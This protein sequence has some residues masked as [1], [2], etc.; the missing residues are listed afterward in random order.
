M[1]NVGDDV[2]QG[3]SGLLGMGG[4]DVGQDEN[5][6]LA[7]DGKRIEPEDEAPKDHDEE[8]EEV[9][10]RV[11]GVINADDLKVSNIGFTLPKCLECDDGS[12]YYGQ[13]IFKDTPI[14]PKNYYG[15]LLTLESSPYEAVIG[16]IFTIPSPDDNSDFIMLIYLCASVGEKGV[17]FHFVNHQWW[18][19]DNNE[20]E[21][22]DFS[23]IITLS[24]RSW[25]AGII[26]TNSTITYVTIDIFRSTRCWLYEHHVYR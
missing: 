24:S 5:D 18:S 23:G 3:V 6:H 19:V 13:A 10:A 17:V 2:A 26:L 16:D 11:V 22:D 25:I 9:P 1:D 4:P 12:C 15:V 20:L 14:I 7:N 21:Q 8:E